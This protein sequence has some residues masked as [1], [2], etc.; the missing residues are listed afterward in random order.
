[1]ASRGR[2]TVI[3]IAWVWLALVIAA[4]AQ[5][6]E[7]EALS[8]ED[9][10]PAPTDPAYPAEAL[11]ARAEYLREVEHWQRS[12]EALNHLIELRR[13]ARV[14]RD[15]SGRIVAIS[16]VLDLLRWRLK[17]QGD[18]LRAEN[19]LHRL[20]GKVRSVFQ[21]EYPSWRPRDNTS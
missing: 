13:G 18:L 7:P 11:K 14:A 15:S 5:H 4:C 9:R 2:R 12:L 17:M 10:L 1:M 20:E 3:A 19:L 21:G 6:M 16:E 8:P